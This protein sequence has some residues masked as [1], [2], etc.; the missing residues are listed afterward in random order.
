MTNSRLQLVCILFYGE[1]YFIEKNC[2]PRLRGTVFLNPHPPVPA[3]FLTRTARSRNLRIP[4]PPAPAMF[5]STPADCLSEI[6]K[7]V[8]K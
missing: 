2:D 1:K 4:V 6:V 5:V 8:H 3:E 7:N